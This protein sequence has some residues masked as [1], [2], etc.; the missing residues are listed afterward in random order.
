M[1]KRTT[2]KT[3]EIVIRPS[4]KI[5]SRQWWSKQLKKSKKL[6][7]KYL[8]NSTKRNLIRN[9]SLTLLLTNNKEIQNLNKRFRNINRSTDVLSFHLNKKEQLKKKYLGDIVIATE[10]AK[11]QAIKKRI[12]L[13]TE[14]Q[15]LL[16]HG[17]L[18]LLGYD[19]K[20]IKQ[21]KTMFSLQNKI[22]LMMLTK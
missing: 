1:N 22:L 20:L 5:R 11:K 19:H 13:E 16:I 18:H 4:S 2:N 10:F 8:N 7:S 17:Y 14:L 6:I 9:S 12:P 3:I 15:M 21:A